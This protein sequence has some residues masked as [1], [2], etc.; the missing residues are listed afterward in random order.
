MSRAHRPVKRYTVVHLTRVF[1][2]QR[3]VTNRSSVLFNRTLGL[4][5]A[6][7]FFFNGALFGAWASRIPDVKSL[8]SLGDAQLGSL[9]LVMAAG[10]IVSFPLAG[11]FIEKTGAAKIALLLAL[12][13]AVAFLMLGISTS[14]ALTALALLVFGASHGGMDVAM[15][16]WGGK[17]EQD[18]KASIM[19]RLHA[20]WSVGAGVGALSG[21]IALRFEQSLFPHFFYWLVILGL[22]G[23]FAVRLPSD[24]PL[25]ETAT[26]KAASSFALP[27]GSLRLIGLIALCAALGEGAMADW[28]A[29]YSV[30]VLNT[31]SSNA[32]ISYACFSAAMV[33]MRLSGDWLIVQT[34]DIRALQLAGALATTGALV[35]T[36][37]PTPLPQFAGL[38]AYPY[39][40]AGF[41]LLGVGYALV[42]PIAF[43]RAARDPHTQPGHAMAATAT[44]G[45]GGMLLGP[46]VIGFLAAVSS[47]QTAFMV[48]V[49]GG[50]TILCLA[51]LTAVDT[52]SKA[53]DVGSR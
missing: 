48:L 41:A 23:F 13:N 50:M 26:K 47:L 8:Y 33:I 34:G 1:P 37:A 35:V 40:L 52:K 9:L 31:S 39:A 19:S 45:Y 24:A 17:V 29:V 46:P 10:A 30:D 20:I 38:P 12:V 3:S 4:P 14:L 27:T 51:P 53:G 22:A 36:T 15:N 28:A 44:L 5:V 49:V 32:A 16:A 7:M 6:F 2:M 21:V 42:M 11:V 43:S 18:N 25:V